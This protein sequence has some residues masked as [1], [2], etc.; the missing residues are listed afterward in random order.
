EM[1]PVGLAVDWVFNHLYWTDPVYQAV[2]MS[3]L[4]GSG[5]VALVT[6]GLSIPR[7]IAV[8]PKNMKLYIG[9]QGAHNIQQCDLDGQ[10]CQQLQNL[11][12]NLF[13]WPNQIT[14]NHQDNKVYW[15]DGWISHV[16]SCDLDGTNC[17]IQN[18]NFTDV[19]SLNP[20]FG[21]A[22]TSGSSY[23]VTTLHNQTI[24]SIN[25][26]GNIQVVTEDQDVEQTTFIISDNVAV[27]QPS[28]P[29]VNHPCRP[30]SHNC[31]G[32]C[33]PSAN[34]VAVC[35]CPSGSGKLANSNGQCIDP[36]SFVVYSNVYSGEVGIADP[37]LALAGTMVIRG[38]KP[39]ALTYDPVQK[40]VYFSDAAMMAIYSCKIDGSEL[41]EILNSSNGIGQVE[42][43]AIDFEQRRL[44]Y[45]NTGYQEKG[46]VHFWHAIE[47]VDLEDTNKRRRVLTAVERPRALYIDSDSRMLYY[48]DWGENNPHVGRVRLD[49]YDRQILYQAVNPNGL[50]ILDNK[51]YVTDSRNR[52]NQSPLL[53]SSNLN[54]TNKLNMPITDMNNVFSIT[55]RA[56]QLLITDLDGNV[57]VY[58]TVGTLQ[59]TVKS[60]GFINLHYTQAMASMPEDNGRCSN[61]VC[62]DICV[63]T[64]NQNYPTCLCPTYDLTYL[65]SDR[66][67]CSR[68]SE[69]IL[70]ADIDGIMMV[71]LA[72]TGDGHT[73]NIIPASSVCGNFHGLARD[74]THIYFS[75]Y[76]G[77]TIYQANL[78]GTNVEEFYTVN[79]HSIV[80]LALYGGSLYWTGITNTTS[81]QGGIY[82]VKISQVGNSPTQYV[83]GVDDP[84]GI[85]VY[86]S[87]IYWT[88]NTSGGIKSKYIQNSN[89]QSVS[90]TG[91]ATIRGLAWSSTFDV[92]FMATNQ[93]MVFRRSPAQDDNR[94][95]DSI[96]NSA[97]MNLVAMDTAIIFSSPWDDST[98]NAS[99]STH[100]ILN[101][102]TRTLSTN[103]VRPGQMVHVGSTV[104]N[105]PMD[106]PGTCP[107]S[108]SNCDI[109]SCRSDYDCYGNQKCCRGT[110]CSLCVDPTPSSV[111]QIGSVTLETGGREQIGCE[112]CSCTGSS[113][114][115]NPVS[116]PPVQSCPEGSR[117]MFPG[118]CCQSCV[119]TTVCTEKPTIS[120][121]P[122]TVIEVNLPSDSN[123]TTF[124]LN[125]LGLSNVMA[126]SCSGQP[127]PIVLSMT[128]LYW[129]KDAQ[130]IQLVASDKQGTTMANVRVKVKDVTPPTIENCPSTSIKV[131]GKTK[132]KGIQVTWQA[133]TANDNAGSQY[134]Q[135]VV[136]DGYNNGD[137]FPVGITKVE[138]RVTDGEGNVATPPCTFSVEVE[139]G[140]DFQCSNPPQLH[141]GYMTCTV[142]GKVLSCQIDQCY[143]G[144]VM[145]EGTPTRY[146]C[147]ANGEWAP[148]AFPDRFTTETCFKPAPS[149]FE[150]DF[151][152]VF[153]CPNANFTLRDVQDCLQSSGFCPEGDITLCDH[154]RL[155]GGTKDNMVNITGNVI[156][157]L[158]YN[159]DQNQ[160]NNQRNDLQN[161]M[162]NLINNIQNFFRNGD[163]ERRCPAI[164]CP[165]SSSSKSDDFSQGCPYGATQHVIMGSKVCA[166]CAPGS[167][168]IS[169]ECQLC[170]PGTYQEEAG[171]DTCTQCPNGENSILGSFFIGQCTL[172]AAPLT[173]KESSSM[174]MVPVIGAVVGVVVLL[175]VVIIII[176]FVKRRQTERKETYS[177]LDNP[178]HQPYTI[179][180][181]AFEM[182]EEYASLS[183]HKMCT[184]DDIAEAKRKKED[185]DAYCQPRR[186][187]PNPYEMDLCKSK[188]D[189]H[190]YG[191]I[192]DGKPEKMEACGGDDDYLQP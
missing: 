67:T 107:S 12:D 1:S 18:K 91:G 144:F 16:R 105:E 64:G 167:R 138:Y 45:T 172:S 77:K 55:K 192:K 36:S 179:P 121:A 102:V 93:G 10:N 180:N 43:L 14:V 9:D 100:D 40:M 182:D 159:S 52:T 63:T 111:C 7:G 112:M 29:N 25:G 92:I 19:I 73:Y 75:S 66:Q 139:S 60:H 65:Q 113:G 84:Y 124:D 13:F 97:S 162:R 15:T 110:T 49:G 87:V 33:L 140:I 142:S 11:D 82:S 133:V 17:Q 32:I 120:N 122:N 163:F 152:L 61:N 175:I 2:M 114:T 90:V 166:K 81:R 131:T 3:N 74:N 161:R 158:E 118:D 96:L 137:E 42:G 185:D 127:L 53:I 70:V 30:G 98:S 71:P 189:D 173:D 116:C 146:T 21:I 165:F 191:Q 190:D 169:G 80:S 68:P 160:Y 46:G 177:G 94:L 95:E 171:Q 58:S 86:G 79:D 150:L 109:Y 103:M 37:D 188:M 23:H 72:D 153:N 168:Y 183:E 5:R 145:K 170:D 38:V 85:A 44:Y 20:L 155:G 62:S 104:S 31:E 129:R 135:K 34:N 125:S 51:L 83:D 54:G 157:L 143:S 164:T 76:L 22:F 47:M 57:G 26:A 8:D 39:L 50:V 4:D 136:T 119:G 89:V 128:K 27:N 28:V 126:T 141:N 69:Y 59:G 132:N 154:Q 174:N 156:G 24:L 148:V 35:A 88:D 115:C 187:E 78:D 149:T 41:R 184:E 99:I 186:A 134:V 48:T 6:K 108:I 101:K 117:V 181:N 123:A 147:D 56:T 151:S 130:T 176:V 106:K 178:N